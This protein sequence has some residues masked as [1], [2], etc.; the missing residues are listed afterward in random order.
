M[1]KLKILL[2]CT[3]LYL[4]LS[5]Y[6]ALSQNRNLIWCFG[7]S[8]GI[9]FSNL[10]NP[11]PITTGMDAR[12]SCTSITKTSGNLQFYAST[13]DP[14]LLIYDELV[15]IRD[16]SNQ[17]MTN[18]D[19]I[20]GLNWYQE[21]VITDNP[22]YSNFY[23]L[24]SIGVTD[25]YGLYYTVI[26][27]SLNGGLGGVVQK[28]VQLDNFKCTDGL[29]A[30]KHGNGRDWWIL[31]RRWDTVNDLFY[32]YL[33]TPSGISNVIIQN[34][35]SP[36]NN[37]FTKMKFSP[38][39]NKF[40]MINLPGLMELYDF[41]R[42]TGD[43]SNPVTIHPEPTSPPYGRF[44]SCEFSLNGRFLYV[45]TNDIN[46]HLYQ[47][48]LLSPNPAT[49]RIIL[50]SNSNYLIGYG[51]LKRGPDDKIYFSTAY[52]CDA[53]PY[54]YPYPDSVYNQYNMNL[55]VINSPDSLGLACN[56][57]PYSFYLGGKRTYYGLPNN[58]DYD[59]PALV[60]S[61]CD[62]LVSINE[63]ASINTNANIHVYYAPDWE[64]AFINAD[65]LKGKNYRLRMIDILGKEV[66][67][68]SGVL[69]S[70]YFTR[71]LNCASFASG[72]YLITFETEKERLVKKM[73][74]NWR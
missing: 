29:T 55:S 43:I 44:W 6:S 63:P 31:L 49:S 33:I 22:G 25:S 10:Q 68:E 23:Y 66:Y 70:Q 65:K 36:T 46:S 26:D 53:F 47:Y 18:G 72:M 61:P 9:D 74:V 73:Q 14:L 39:G 51:F 38:D 60:G 5:S 7:D 56:Y 45:A 21:L 28:N 16:A 54:C 71:D 59:M 41:D 32:K 58:P 42:C 62:T 27:M 13:S 19:S 64:K 15:Y 3:F 67:S 48:D 35:G 11:I 52:Q 4:L 8:A 37:G 34:I 50:T 30:I 2:N 20:V 40:A 69:N 1:K 57:T 17:V 24:F 12:G